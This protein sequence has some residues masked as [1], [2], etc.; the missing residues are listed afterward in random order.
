MHAN[1][2][3][4][5]EVPAGQG[6]QPAAPALSPATE[7]V[8]ASHGEQTVAAVMLFVLDPAAQSRHAFSRAEGANLPRG[9]SVQ[10]RCE[11]DAYW[12]ALGGWCSWVSWAGF[13]G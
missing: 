4:E 13:N 10:V 3:Y 12:P 8:P 11:G 6:S 5:L 2:P 7:A 9:Q 1:W